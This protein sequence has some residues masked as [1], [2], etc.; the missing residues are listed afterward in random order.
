MSL[1]SVHHTRERSV[2]YPFA[3]RELSVQPPARILVAG[4]ADSVL[5]YTLASL[6]YDVSIIDLRGYQL[7]HPNL[8]AYCGDLRQLPFES[9]CFDAIVCIS[10]IEHVGHGDTDSQYPEHAAFEEFDRTLIPKGNLVLTT[11][12]AENEEL[13][14]N[15]RVYSIDRFN[16]VL[17]SNLEIVS[18]ETFSRQGENWRAS[19]PQDLAP[20]DG[21]S[22][23]NVLCVK[24]ARPAS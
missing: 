21:H 13:L 6:G 18:L 1:G 17:P 10:V 2:E 5:A 22:I 4:G 11:P 7:Q 23:S 12:L 16:S 9:E 15:G 20:F 3:Y 8:S 14:P 24:I 19:S